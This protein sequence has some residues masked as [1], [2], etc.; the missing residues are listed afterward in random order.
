VKNIAIAL[1]LVVCGLAFA[2]SPVT[3]SGLQVARSS[4]EVAQ[5]G[6]TALL[7][8]YV[9][10]AGNQVATRQ[11]NIEAGCGKITDNA[12]NTLAA[13]TPPA[14][15]TAITTFGNQLDSVIANAASGGKLNL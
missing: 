11:I 8:V 13:T 1:V 3:T 2:G 5:D 4:V 9:N 10:A 15:C 12:G 6:A 7:L 14:L